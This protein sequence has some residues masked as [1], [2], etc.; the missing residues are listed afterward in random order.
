M[1]IY[2]CLLCCYGVPALREIDRQ[3]GQ[4]LQIENKAHSKSYS[5][6]C[7]GNSVVVHANR[8]FKRKNNQIIKKETC[9]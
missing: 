7:V 4:F 6:I 2:D 3:R 1:G 5:E 9:M 8:V